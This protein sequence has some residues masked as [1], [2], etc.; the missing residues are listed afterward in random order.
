MSPGVGA[1]SSSTPPAIL[2]AAEQNIGGL[3]AFRPSGTSGSPD[4]GDLAN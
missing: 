2:P 1:P 4:L 3:F